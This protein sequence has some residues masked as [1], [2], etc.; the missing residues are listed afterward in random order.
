MELVVYLMMRS[1]VS[2]RIMLTHWNLNKRDA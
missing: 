1:T 2:T